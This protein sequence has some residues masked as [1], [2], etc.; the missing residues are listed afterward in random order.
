LADGSVASDQADKYAL[1][2]HANKLD[3]ICRK[4]RLKPFTEHIQQNKTR[5]GVLKNDHSD[6]VAELGKHCLRKS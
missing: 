5:F 4:L 3:D 1:H 6:L 2:R